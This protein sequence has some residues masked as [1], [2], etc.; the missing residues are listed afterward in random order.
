MIKTKIAIPLLLAS[1]I[2]LNGCSFFSSNDTDV[3]GEFNARPKLTYNKKAYPVTIEEVNSEGKMQ[4]FTYNEP[5]ERIIAVWQDSIETLIAL[6]VGERIMAG[7]GVPDSKYLL[8]ENRAV[9]EKIPIKSLQNLS[10][11][12]VLSM[13]PDFILGWY[14]TFQDKSLKGTEFWL[15][16]G[17]N[18][19]ISQ[20]SVSRKLGAKHNLESQY[21][22]IENLGKIFDRQEKAKE[23]VD[24]MKEEI[25]RVTNY[26]ASET[27]HPKALVMEFAGRGEIDIYNQNSL[28]GN[29]VEKLHGE[30]LG[31]DMDKIGY[32]QIV[33]MN[34]DVIFIVVVERDYTEADKFLKKVY[35]NE[36]IRGVDAVKNKRVFLLPLY[37]VYSA[38]IRSLDGIQI[39]S[40]GLYPNMPQEDTQR[41]SDKE[42]I[43][44]EFTPNLK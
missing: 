21:V 18:T 3:M 33:Q 35:D 19:Y 6:G 28:A 15:S 8:P 1:T 10:L 30:L 24:K 37:A 14:S 38:G 41:A 32:E 43:S 5:P 12:T 7:I 29:M 13:H 26:T 23:I 40:K 22:Y 44:N 34:P 39:I 20:S 31:R 36:S 2:I 17:V 4:Q 42:S 27:V 16:R 11:E 9:Y 25:D